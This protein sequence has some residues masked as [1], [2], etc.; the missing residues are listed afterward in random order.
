MAH[1]TFPPLTDNAIFCSTG[2]PG[3]VHL[4]WLR[5][6]PTHDK[7]SIA[8]SLAIQLG[9]V[10]GAQIVAR[11]EN[12]VRVWVVVEVHV[13]CFSKGG[14]NSVVAGGLIRRVP[15]AGCR[16]RDHLQYVARLAQLRVCNGLS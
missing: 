3:P 7:A 5:G 14:R 1:S 16:A 6:K 11:D 13:F 10:I 4:E 12:A 9:L 8:I 15:E 2:C